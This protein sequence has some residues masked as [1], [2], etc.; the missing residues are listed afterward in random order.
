VSWRLTKEDISGQAPRKQLFDPDTTL[1]AGFYRV[2]HKD[3]SG[4]G[5]DRGHM[6]PHADR[7]ATEEMSFA[8]FVMTNIIPQAPNVNQKTWADLEDYCRV[9]AR[10]GNRLYIT[11]GPAGRGGRGSAG[12]KQ[13]IAGGKVTVPAECW[14]VIVVVPGGGGS[15]D[16]LATISGATRVIAVIMPNENDIGVDWT[17]YR[18]SAGEVEGRT[19]LHFFDR[20][21]AE[22]AA[23]LRQKVDAMPVSGGA[24]APVRRR[25]TR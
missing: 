10:Q 25:G 1:P 20:L 4:S 14:K 18:T 21:P 6:C 15:A 9:L 13:T 19:G 24:V 3:Y 7:D 17:K 8:T 16:D 5:F 11:A 12:A 23:A 2:V 22:V